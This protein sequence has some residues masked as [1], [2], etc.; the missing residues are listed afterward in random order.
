MDDDMKKHEKEDLRIVKTKTSLLNALRFLLREKNFVNITVH[1]LC[2]SAKVSRTAMYSN[3]KNKYVLLKESLLDTGQ[4]FLD[5]ARICGGDEKQIEAIV[6][7]YVYD[8]RLLITNLLSESD[9]ELFDIVSDFLIHFIGCAVSGEKLGSI[10]EIDR[11][12]KNTKNNGDDLLRKSLYTFC[13]G[14]ILEVLLSYARKRFPPDS[15][16]VAG[17]IYKLIRLIIYNDDIE[18]MIKYT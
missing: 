9:A 2:E 16:E 1:E 5:S 3:Y 7:K 17:Y 11:S 4:E 12:I 18:N 8:Y 15:K 14:G 6:G 10:E 13:A